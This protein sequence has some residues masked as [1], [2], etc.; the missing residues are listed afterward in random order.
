MFISTVWFIINHFLNSFGPILLLGLLVKH[1]LDISIEILYIFHIGKFS[2]FLTCT[3][4]LGNKAF[5]SQFV[6]EFLHS[7]M[8][9]FLAGIL[10]TCFSTALLNYAGMFGSPRQ[11]LKCTMFISTVWFIINHFLN[12]FGP[13]LLLGLLVKHALDISIEILY[14]FHIGKFSPFLTCTGLLGNKAFI[15][16]FVF[17]FLHSMMNGFLAGILMTCFSTQPF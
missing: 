13:I 4:L 1:A 17:E 8:N 2:P 7:M 15:S 16:Q 5:I 9:G 11:N 3:G 6:F 14:I 10:M 12:S